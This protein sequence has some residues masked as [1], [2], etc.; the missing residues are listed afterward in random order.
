MSLSRKFVIVLMIS[1][2]SIAIVNILAFYVFYNSYI[3]LYLSEKID[4]RQNVTIEY[5]NK[6]I[7]RQTLEDIDN[8]F[9]DVELEFFELL[10]LSDGN[11]PLQEDKNVNIVIDYLV[12]SWV[13]PKYIEEI[14]PE[15][16]LEKILVLLQDKNSPETRFITRLFISLIFTNIIVLLLIALWVLYITKKIIFPIKRATNEIKTLDFWKDSKKIK[17]DKKDEIWLLIQ[18]INGLNSRLSI[19]EKIRS[20]LL[21]DISHELKT[22]ITS[23]QCYLEWISDWVI[24]LSE[25]NLASIIS[26]MTRL[27][28]LVNQIMEYEKFENSQI[29]LK[30]EAYNPY[31]LISAVSETQKIALEETKQSII[32]SWSK[33]IEIYLD[34]DLFTQLTYNLIWNFKKYAWNCTELHIPISRGKITFKDNGKGIAKKEIPFLFEKFY[35]GKKEKTGNIS[36]RGIWVWLSIVKKIIAAHNW[37]W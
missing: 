8:I 1:V 9:S 25:K 12:K 37:K 16:N 22:P 4:S 5:I 28:E 15:N 11:I 17:Y 27:T 29:E 31:E 21:A 2:C 19:Q 6:I 3:R 14:I 34:K 24:Q 20:R 18:S 32:I 36:V 30:K 23:I 13:S 33:N 35:Q 10:D 26:E 7:E